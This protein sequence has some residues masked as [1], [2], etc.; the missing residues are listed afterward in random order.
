MPLCR[1]KSGKEALCCLRPPADLYPTACPAARGMPSHTMT[2]APTHRA[3]I[4]TLQG[5]ALLTAYRHRLTPCGKQSSEYA[6]NPAAWG[7][8]SHTVLARPRPAGHAYARSRGEHGSL[9]T[10]TG[11]PFAVSDPANMPSVR[12]HGEC[13]SRLRLSAASHASGRAAPILPP[14]P[15]HSKKQDT[16]EGVSCFLWDQ[17]GVMPWQNGSDRNISRYSGG[18]VRCNVPP[19]R[20]AAA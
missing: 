2:P 14:N 18:T 1:G 16:P 20:H 3:C 12:R 8:P 4:R 19:D 17:K 7:M 11:S 9:P 10:D 13:L 6:A 15:P 5:E